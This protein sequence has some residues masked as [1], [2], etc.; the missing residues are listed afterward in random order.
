MF[1]KLL[2]SLTNSDSNFIVLTEHPFRDFLNVFSLSC[3]RLFRNFYPA[4]YYNSFR[5]FRYL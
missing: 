3:F 1:N 5:S 4:N 2:K